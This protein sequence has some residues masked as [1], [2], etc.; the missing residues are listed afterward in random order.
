MTDRQPTPGVHENFADQVSTTAHHCPCGDNDGLWCSLPEC[1]FPKAGKASTPSSSSKVECEILNALRPFIGKPMTDESVNG[2]I[3]AIRS[4]GRSHRATAK[5]DPPAIVDAST[6]RIKAAVEAKC[7]GTPPPSSHLDEADFQLLDQ[8][9]RD[10]IVGG[11]RP[12]IESQGWEQARRLSDEGLI[13]IESVG[14]GGRLHITRKGMHAIAAFKRG[15]PPPSSH[16]QGGVEPTKRQ[17]EAAIE[18]YENGSYLNDEQVLVSVIAIV[19]A[20]LAAEGQ[21]DA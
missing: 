2:M 6:D 19:R 18:A 11:A 20:A 9:D 13:A 8:L 4:V 10:N 1:P 17:I 14:L 12:V 7:D 21:A 3:N 5:D 16:S 15:T